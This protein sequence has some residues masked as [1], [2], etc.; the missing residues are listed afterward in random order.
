MYITGVEQLDAAAYGAHASARLFITP[1]EK[2]V[3]QMQTIA[4]LFCKYERYEEGARR[5]ERIIFKTA[6][7]GINSYYYTDALG[8]IEGLLTLKAKKRLYLNRKLLAD[9]LLDIMSERE[10]ECVRRLFIERRSINSAAAAAGIEYRGFIR[11][12]RRGLEHAYDYL[13]R[14]NNPYYYRLLSNV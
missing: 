1:D 14:L 9:E 10:A 12:A 11:A 7:Y 5:L 2:D 3:G 8:E 4:S 13:E 6:L